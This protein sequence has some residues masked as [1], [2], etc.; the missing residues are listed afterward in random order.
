MKLKRY[1]S[2][3]PLLIFTY[4]FGLFCIWAT[5]HII[6]N[7]DLPLQLLFLS[8]LGAGFALTGSIFHTFKGHVYYAEVVVPV[9]E[10]D[11]YKECSNGAVLIFND[12]GKRVTSLSVKRIRQNNGIT[13]LKCYD[14]KKK[15]VNWTIVEV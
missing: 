13:L 2:R 14:R 12:F 8:I 15:L 11:L 9:H 1:W 6:K 10:L 7:P 4:S 5:Y 3:I